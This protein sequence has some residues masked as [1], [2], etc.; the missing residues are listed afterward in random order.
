MSSNGGAPS[1]GAASPIRFVIPSAPKRRKLTE[2][3]P[4]APVRAPP[5]PPHSSSSSASVLWG[6]DDGIESFSSDDDHD[7]EAEQQQHDVKAAAVEAIP[8]AVVDRLHPYQRQGITFLCEAFAAGQGAILADEMGLGKTVQAVGFIGCLKGW[9]SP[10]VTSK[11]QFF[12]PRHRPP[13]PSNAPTTAAVLVVTPASVLHQWHREFRTW[14]GLRAF[15]GHG[16]A[17]VDMLD[18]ARQ[19][20]LDVLIISYET[21]KSDLDQLNTISFLCAIFDEAHRIKSNKSKLFKACRRL[22]VRI[23]F[24]LTGTLIQNSFDELYHLV[25]FLVPNLLGDA[26]HFKKSYAQP[27]TLGFSSEA[28]DAQR[29][30]ARDAASRLASTLTKCM[31]RRTKLSVSHQ[32]PPKEETV[33]FCQ[34]TDQQRTVYRDTL[35]SRQYEI[36]RHN[37][38]TCSCGSNYIASKCCHKYDQLSADAWRQLALP[39]ITSLQQIASHV[40]SSDC[41][42]QDD[43]SD[44]SGKFK[45]L[46]T[47]LSEW[48]MQGDKILLFSNSMATLDLLEL[49]LQ[50][51]TAMQPELSMK[52]IRMDGSTAV[53]NRQKMIDTFNKGNAPILLVST[54]ACGT[55]I[56]LS[57]ANVVVLFEPNWNVSLDAQAADRAHRLGQQRTTRVYRLVSAGTIE[58]LMYRRQVY[59]QQLVNVAHMDATQTKLKLFSNADLFGSALLFSFTETAISFPNGQLVHFE[60]I[61]STAA[62]SAA[63]DTNQTSNHLLDLLIGRALSIASSSQLD[64]FSSE[65]II[66]D[67]IDPSEDSLPAAQ[68]HGHPSSEFLDSELDYRSLDPPYLEDDIL[69]EFDGE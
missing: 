43:P 67:V 9:G 20:K 44:L 24:G 48:I 31:L 7:D 68:Q 41:R 27:I 37:V 42:Q 56:N 4:D 59:K 2:T 65:A 29:A 38:C 18:K 52:H 46:D 39:A 58:E 5:Q 25:H 57:S 61:E 36:L 69:I 33:V 54:R 8:A 22:A 30:S 23:R 21:L 11:Q 28:T 16:K 19:N 53:A 14:T 50:Q 62:H 10:S 66:S 34:L 3:E 40:Y 63:S 1:R 55:G 49:Y 60:R 51:R 47:Y 35:Q 13:A 45:M 64:G 32:L 12:A 15:I 17:K 6:H 26:D